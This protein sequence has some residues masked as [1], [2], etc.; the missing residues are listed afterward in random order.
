MRRVGH[1]IIV[2][3]L[4]LPILA[5]WLPGISTSVEARDPLGPQGKSASIPQGKSVREGREIF[6]H[7]TFGDEQLWT[8]VLRMHE[9]IPKAVTP[10]VALSVGL[11]VD[12]Q[13]LPKT[14]VSA[15]RAG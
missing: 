13:A 5:A 11:K 9:V 7:D 6:R 3:S 1:L 10:K 2:A 4:A 14:I 12:V 8:D 15:L